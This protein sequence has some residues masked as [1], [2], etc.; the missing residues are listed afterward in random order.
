M[1]A[2]APV[3]VVEADADAREA[4]CELVEHCN[5]RSLAFADVA[6][7]HGA[8][9]RDS[10]GFILSCGPRDT[11]AVKAFIGELR[12][13]ALHASTPIIVLTTVLGLDAF[14]GA[15][16]VMGKPFDA[17]VLIEKICSLG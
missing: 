13:T 5:L 11:I 10:V 6:A 2:T 16:L 12:S 7:A 9:A 1:T 14:P 17:D 3:V 15:T 8:L 4:I